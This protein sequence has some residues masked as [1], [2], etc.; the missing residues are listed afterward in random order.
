MPSPAGIS[1][2]SPAVPEIE[3]LLIVR[4]GAMGDVIHGLPAAAALRDAFPEAMIGWL[5]E[6]RWAEL[7]CT[8][9]AP[10][11]GPRSPQRPVVDRIHTVNTRQWR[12]AP[13]SLQTWER[14]AAGLSDLRAVH[15]EI[16]L[17]LQGAVRSSLLAKWSGAEVIYGATQPRENLASM[18]YT[19]QVIARDGHVVEQNVSLAEAVA[20]R[21]LK[22]PPAQLPLDSATEQEIDRWLKERKLQEFALLNPGAGWA[23]KQWPAER[24]GEVARHLADSGVKSLINFGPGEEE[25]ART[26][27]AASGGAADRFTGSLTQLIALTRRA[28]LF[29][30]GDTGPMHLAAAL[31][32]PVVGIFGPTSPARNGPFGARNIVLRSPSSATSYRHVATP[33]SG[34]LEISCEH[35]VAAAQQLLKERTVKEQHG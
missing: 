7:L 35:V 12:A 28:R 33:D 4:L 10:R 15:Y 1:A 23:A 9:P 5:I 18:F 34:L 3:T 31:E 21:P 32:V 17:D 26:V 24:Y 2:E 11:S 14:I 19:R 16:A 20:G 22:R 29:I 25:I 6:E 27:E 30:G 8:L 13:F